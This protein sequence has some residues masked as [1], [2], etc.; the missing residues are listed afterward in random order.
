LFTW[1]APTEHWL[2][3]IGFTFV[4]GFSQWE[5]QAAQVQAINPLLIL[6]LIP[7]F[8]CFLYPTVNKVVRFTPLRKI[9]VGLFLTVLSFL[10]AGYAETL[11]GKGQTP[12]IWWQMLAFVIIT[13]AEVMV[14][15]TCLEFSYTQAPKKMKSLIMGVY[16]LSIASG[17]LFTF[18]VNYFIQNRDK[19]TKLNG[20]DYYWFFSGLMFVASVLFC[21]YATF[22]RE[23]TYIQGEAGE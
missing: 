19:T 3:G 15:I 4:K 13:A 2:V 6:G 23:K 16:L 7:L 5:I 10:I 11:I 12:S 9:G 21:V 18:A 17:N 20:P 8:T 22:Y 1:A 14:S